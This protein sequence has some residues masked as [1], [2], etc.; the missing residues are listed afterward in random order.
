M[1][2]KAPLEAVEPPIKSLSQPPR[3]VGNSINKPTHKTID[4]KTL[5]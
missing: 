5:K 2:S 4:T 1:L 3:T